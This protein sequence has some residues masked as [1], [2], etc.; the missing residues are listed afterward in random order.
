MKPHR[1][2]V[3]MEIEKQTPNVQTVYSTL[4][5]QQRR[6]TPARVGV[7]DDFFP[8][9]QSSELAPRVIIIFI[10]ECIFRPSKAAEG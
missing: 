4:N 10:I 3:E 6:R 7:G 1:L 5:K 8:E 2:C 9:A